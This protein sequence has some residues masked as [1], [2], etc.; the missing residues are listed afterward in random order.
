MRS[1]FSLAFLVSA[2]W[3]EF[4]QE[5]LWLFLVL[6]IG[7]K[8]FFLLR[9]GLYNAI[10]RYAGL[11]LAIEIIKAMTYASLLGF[12]I[13]HFPKPQSVPL[14]FFATDYLAST[15]LVGLIRFAPR[16]FRENWRD[17]GSKRLLIYGAGELGET[18]ARKMI[19]LPN[20]YRLVGFLDDSPKKIG[21]RLHNL[22]IF[23]PVGRLGEILAKERIAEV[24]IAIST[25]PGE[26]V[27]TITHECR[28]NGVFCRIVP[29]FSDMLKKDISVKNIDISDLLKRK[30]RSGR[31]QIMRF[32]KD[33][34]VMISGAGDRS[35]R[36][37]SRQCLRYGVKK[38]V[39][40]DH[41][42]STFTKSKK[43]SAHRLFPSASPCS[44]RS[45]N[46]S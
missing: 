8:I 1:S 12:F 13:I 40:F 44:T 37:L 45:T 15:F 6:F 31:A 3:F 32:L 22:P 42:R 14:G 23:G 33:K 18:V 38:L 35:A 24:I 11:P 9:Y 39:L 46:P 4:N 30:P 36:K 27:R 26:D 34:V 29:S 28:K 25:L 2:K 43:S 5:R 21:L 20:E 7:V 41:S 17:T 16:Y 19:R 10:L